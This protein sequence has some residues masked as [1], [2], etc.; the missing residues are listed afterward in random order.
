M[1]S[2]NPLPIRRS[3]IL[4]LCSNK[5]RFTTAALPVVPLTNDDVGRLQFHESA[6]I[7]SLAGKWE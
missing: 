3:G 1:P 5:V 7:E 4:H 2:G 6:L